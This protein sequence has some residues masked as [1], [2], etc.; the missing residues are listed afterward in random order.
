MA[1]PFPVTALCLCWLLCVQLTDRPQCWSWSPQPFSACH[2]LPQSCLPI[3]S[4]VSRRIR[5]SNPWLMVQGLLPTVCTH[6]FAAEGPEP[7]EQAE[8]HQQQ[9]HED[10]NERCHATGL[11][12]QQG[13]CQCCFTHLPQKPALVLL[14]SG[15]SF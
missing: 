15:G 2:K 3:T 1:T 4:P 8:C 7:P 10:S 12:R 6:H 9:Q 11:W 5:V 14:R 13:Q